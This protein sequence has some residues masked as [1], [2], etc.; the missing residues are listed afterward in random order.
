MSE[1]WTDRSMGGWLTPDGYY[2]V[3]IQKRNY[4][5]HRLAYETKYGKIPEGLVI[6]HLCRNRAC[7]NP[8]HL[9]VVTQKENLR[10]GLHNN[11]NNQNKGKTHCKNQAISS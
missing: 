1:C 4:L 9:E 8:D 5:V 11:H 7:Y 3:S 6:D 10:R 2:R